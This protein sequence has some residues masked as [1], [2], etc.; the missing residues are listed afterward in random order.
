MPCLK[1]HCCT[2]HILLKPL[3]TSCSIIGIGR[4][5]AVPLLPHHR[6]YGS[7]TTVVRCIESL[8]P[9]RNARQPRFH[10]VAHRQG[11]G[12]CRNLRQSP[13]SMGRL[14]RVPP[15]AHADTA[16]AQVPTAGP[17]PLFPEVAAQLAPDP[18]VDVAKPTP[19]SPGSGLA[20]QQPTKP[21]VRSSFV[22]TDEAADGKQVLQN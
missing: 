5:L 13:R 21:R 1:F 2:P 10:K 15:V 17:A 16:L 20:L 12:D 11:Q 22:A 18:L 19:Q 8:L 14:T 7:R 9:C 4:H 6:P 3:C